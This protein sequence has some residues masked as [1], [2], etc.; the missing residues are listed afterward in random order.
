MPNFWAE[1]FPTSLGCDFEQRRLTADPGEGG[2]GNLIFSYIR[3]L[4]P[5]WGVQNLEFQYF[6]G[7]SEK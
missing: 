4:G 2:G 1:A 3:R 7:F 6:W 5:F